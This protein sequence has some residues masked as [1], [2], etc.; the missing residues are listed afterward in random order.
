MES[1]ANLSHLM[2][3]F[4]DTSSIFPPLI[5]GMSPKRQ[6]ISNASKS[7]LFGSSDKKNSHFL[8]THIVSLEDLTMNG[9]AVWFN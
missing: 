9:E 4:D 6:Y 8:Y 7:F 5:S 2:S 3:K 1:P